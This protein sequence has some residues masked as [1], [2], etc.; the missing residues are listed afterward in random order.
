MATATACEASESSTFWENM[1]KLLDLDAECVKIFSE[2]READVNTN[3]T[4]ESV[5]TGSM[6]DGSNICRFASADQAIMEFDIQQVMARIPNE[7]YDAIVETIP[8]KPD[9]VKLMDEDKLVFYSSHSVTEEKETTQECE[10]CSTAKKL[11]LGTPKRRRFLSQNDE[12]ILTASM[13]QFKE[14]IPNIA[15]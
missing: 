4:F 9:N 13:D 15:T 8:G 7:Q 2:K 11:K 3:S 12:A 10:A 5:A 1:Y 6:A 14:Y